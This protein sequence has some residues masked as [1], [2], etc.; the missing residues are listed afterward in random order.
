MAE[1]VEWDGDGTPRNPRFGDIYRSTTGGL[2]QARHVFLR[3]CGLPEAWRGREA[4]CIAETGFGLG[5]NFLATWRAW[6]DDPQRPRVLHFFS[7]EAYPVAPGD[8]LR[9]AQAYPELQE[10]AGELA[11]QWYGLLPG[12]H[13]L[14]FESG[15]VQLT[16][17][18]GDAREVLK[19]QRFAADCVFLD[20]FDPERNPAMWE[21][22]V[23]K[24][25]ARLCKRGA[26][27]ATWTVAG[28]VRRALAQCGFRVEKA[29]GLPPKRHCLRG[30]YAPEW[31]TRHAPPE[32]TA[33]GRAIVIGGGLAGAAVAHSLAR[34]GWR[35]EVR[36][37]APAPASG[38]SGLPVGLCTPHQSPDDNLLSKLTRAGIRVTLAE[39]ARLLR[40]REDYARSGVLE[41]RIGDAREPPGANEWTRKADAAQ[42][43]SAGLPDH[44]N[45]WWHEAAGWVR[46]AAL[47][48]AWLGHPS[49]TWRG[50]ERVASLEALQAEADLVVVAAAHGSMAL[51]G[52][53]I[54][55]N[56]VRGQATWAAH[57]PGMQVPP[58]AVNGNGHLL[59]RVTLDGADCWITGATYGRGESDTTL[60]AA[61]DA[62]N[63]ERLRALLPA[64]AEQVAPAFAG[65][66]T[67]SWAG[68]RCVSNDRR[69][70]VGPVAPRVWVS[71]AMG[72]RGLSFAA[73]CGELLA[74][75]LH[76]EPLPLSP[77]LADSLAVERVLQ[78]E[79]G[80]QAAPALRGQLQIS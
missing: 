3:G 9:S 59:P 46:P 17:G 56:S 68:V 44:D 40:E 1:A 13:R 23:L 35:V 65:G 61:D 21:V 24:G 39:C 15:Q 34:R 37:A 5:L 49:I 11:R 27:V 47:V 67:R 19:T 55:L 63:L 36:D 6:R 45:A 50:G 79:K 80:L 74:A 57:T 54:H 10:L 64:F 58:F 51:L 30:S 38:A 14:S 29:D 48:R 77:T 8:I 33:P 4:W 42:L 52:D 31:A 73:L 28:D 16:L 7:V 75:R 76:A 41:R 60:R 25:M 66:R 69:P 18:I 22:P 32:G 12:V 62:A 78:R 26:G 2:E 71:T 43:R 72:S 20:G 53:A 70:L